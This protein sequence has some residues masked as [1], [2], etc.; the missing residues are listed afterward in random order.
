[1]WVLKSSRVTMAEQFN[2]YPSF[3]AKETNPQNPPLPRSP[4]NPAAPTPKLFTTCP[5]SP[6]ARKQKNNSSTKYRFTMI[7]RIPPPSL[8][9]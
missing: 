5:P 9:S 7:L 8:S 2:T 3:E 1:M 4:R 6:D